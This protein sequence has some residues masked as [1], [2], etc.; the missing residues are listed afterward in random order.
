MY[1]PIVGGGSGR[2]GG[3]C[4]PPPRP[5]QS[6]ALKQY[7]IPIDPSRPEAL[8]PSARAEYCINTKT[9]TQRST[10]QS[11]QTLG[12]TNSHILQQHATPRCGCAK[13]GALKRLIR[14]AF[15]IFYFV[16]RPT[17]PATRPRPVRAVLCTTSTVGQV[18]RRLASPCARGGAPTLGASFET[19]FRPDRPDRPGSGRRP[20]PPSPHHRHERERGRGRQGEAGAGALGAGGCVGGGRLPTSTTPPDIST[21]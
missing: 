13:S 18:F 15:A 17:P 3:D 10:S 16:S 20:L 19:S 14:I 5:R 12:E 21:F 2:R 8:A 9:N 6:I 4:R 7:T 11:T 1:A